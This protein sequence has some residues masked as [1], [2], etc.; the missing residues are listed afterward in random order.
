M[1]HP[2]PAQFWAGLLVMSGAALVPDF[3]E[4]GSTIARDAGFIGRGFAHL[5]RRAS[6]GHRHGT[7][8]LLGAAVFTL[9]AWSAVA[10]G[11]HSA[12]G[13]VWLWLWLSLL[14]SAAL[15]ILPLVRHGHH[16][17]LLGIAG[18]A[19]LCYWQ[20]GLS[21]VPAC[22]GAGVLVHIAGDELTHHGCPLLWPVS[23]HDFHLLPVQFTTGKFFEHWIVSPLLTIALVLVLAHDAGVPGLLAPHLTR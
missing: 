10:A 22:V 21:I 11:A 16:T 9:A 15:R 6:G 4:P 12:Y 7:H 14:M 17:D 3:D 23:D 1:L 8:S 5:V 18:A 20:P 13:R 2:N 19:A